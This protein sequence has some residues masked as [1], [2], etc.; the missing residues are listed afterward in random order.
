M[1]PSI[2]K[3]R[4][5]DNPLFR[6]GRQNYLPLITFTNTFFSDIELVS[7]FCDFYYFHCTKNEVFH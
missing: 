2:D 5:K 7:G 6:G 1:A 3:K 4:F